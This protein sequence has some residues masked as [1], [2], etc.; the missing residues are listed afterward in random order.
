MHNLYVE[1][2]WLNHRQKS[3]RIYR[4]PQLV[5]SLHIHPQAI[6]AWSRVMVPM[7]FQPTGMSPT[8]TE[9]R[10]THPNQ[11]VNCNMS[12]TWEAHRFKDFRVSQIS[13]DAVFSCYLQSRVVKV[14]LLICYFTLSWDYPSLE[15]PRWQISLGQGLVGYKLNTQGPIWPYLL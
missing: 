2:I 3:Y 10:Q 11:F 13:T 14:N 7:S 9:N 5:F 4:P 8:W 15:R 1:L 6:C 12:P